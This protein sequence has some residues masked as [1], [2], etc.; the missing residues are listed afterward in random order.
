MRR[1][2]PFLVFLLGLIPSA[3]RAATPPLVVMVEDASEPFSRR[4]GTGYANDIVR[5]AF[6][7]AGV[8]VRLDVVPYARC[9]KSLEDGVTPACFAMSWEPEFKNRVVFSD[10]PLFEVHAD[11][12]ARRSARISGPQ[13][14]RPGSTL[15]II[16]GYEYPDAI[17]ALARRGVMLV[18]NV[19]EAANLQMLAKG[20]LDAAVM[21]TSE[22]ENM[23]RRISWMEVGSAVKLAFRAGLMK[24]YIGFT[25]AN[26]RGEEA[27]LAFNR[28]YAIIIA[29]RT[30]DRI[31]N[32]WMK[33]AYQIAPAPASAR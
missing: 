17:Q 5:A 8:A 25:P 27:R 4:D 13:G 18:G 15:G 26:P 30:K 7:A 16:N 2:V 20:R 19:S 3:G 9:K 22:I 31:R 24:S 10:L 11:V 23:P 33:K 12:Y 29:N 6:K 32:A 1:A 21:M 14:L 28:G